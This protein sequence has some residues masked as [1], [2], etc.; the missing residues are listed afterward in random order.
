L[1]AALL[2]YARSENLRV[3]HGRAAR[4]RVEREYS[5]ER[6]LGDYRALYRNFC[7]ERRELA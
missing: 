3:A 5:L 6:M 2:D 4:L 1:A 7:G